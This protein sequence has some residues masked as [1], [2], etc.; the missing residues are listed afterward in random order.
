MSDIARVSSDK[1]FKLFKNYL[2]KDDF[3]GADLAR[4]FLQ[5]GYT[6]SLPYTNYK[7]GK[8]YHSVTGMPP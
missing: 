4:K 7:G 5:M 8:K 1:I 3:F 2:K 6:R